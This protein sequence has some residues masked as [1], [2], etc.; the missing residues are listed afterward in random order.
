[1]QISTLCNLLYVLLFTASGQYGGMVYTGLPLIPDLIWYFILT[2]L[3]PW[4]SLPH[5]KYEQW[6][7]DE[8]MGEL[9]TKVVVYKDENGTEAS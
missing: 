4:L 6:S 3:M 7:Q 8:S 2:I 1:M 9:E 5:I